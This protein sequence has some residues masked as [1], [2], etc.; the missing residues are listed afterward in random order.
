MPK[1]PL[2]PPTHPSTPP[3]PPKPPPP[4]PLPTT[5]CQIQLQNTSSAGIRCT[6]VQVKVSLGWSLQAHLTIIGRSNGGAAAP[7]SGVLP[8]SS[9]LRLRGAS[10]EDW[11]LTFYNI[12][13]NLVIRNSTISGVPLNSGWPLL[14]CVN[15]AHVTVQG[16]QILAL[17]SSAAASG[18]KGAVELVGVQ[19]VGMQDVTCIGVAHKQASGGVSAAC[20]TVFYS[21]S[22][23]FTGPASGAQLSLT[24]VHI[25]NNT[26]TVAVAGSSAS[27]YG[28]FVIAR[29]PSSGSSASSLSAGARSSLQ[30]D[31]SIVDS[32][33]VG[34]RGIRGAALAFLGDE[35]FALVSVMPAI[36]LIGCGF[37]SI[38]FLLKFIHSGTPRHQPVRHQRQPGARAGWSNL[39]SKSCLQPRSS[40]S[41]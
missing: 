36:V 38:R 33:F 6:G 19:S 24:R 28:A 8:V 17:K 29:Q 25:T 35:N 31:M 32:A 41:A 37:D 5:V 3:S 34:N 11:G 18:S 23:P 40:F 1:P 2:A 15:C 30:L 7:L 20:F 12:S 16:T 9:A 10:I 27:G 39:A 22:L 14:G 13:H 21:S 26:A 4:P